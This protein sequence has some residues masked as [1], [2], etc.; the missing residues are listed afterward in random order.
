MEVKQK[1]IQT[2]D[3]TLVSIIGA[4]FKYMFDLIKLFDSLHFYIDK[5]QRHLFIFCLESYI[6]GN[7]AVRG[8]PHGYSIITDSS[9]CRKACDDLG[10]PVATISGGHPCYEDSENNCNQNGQNGQGA[11]FVCAKSGIL[12]N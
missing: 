11:K 7:L 6:R 12:T 2:K 9:E 5:S 10:I 1:T 3:P 8:C 4:K